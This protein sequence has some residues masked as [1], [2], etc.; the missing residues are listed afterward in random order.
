MGASGYGRLC[1]AATRYSDLW[2]TIVLSGNRI[3]T[4]QPLR[5]GAERFLIADINNPA[6]SASAQSNFAIM[7]DNSFSGGGY[8]KGARHCNHIPGGANVLY[9]D[10][11]VEWAKYPQPL[12]SK[13]YVMTAEAQGDET[14]ASP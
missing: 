14:W 7:W 13:A 5:E 9:M 12:G 2:A 6:S 3:V 8:V 1:I 11:H 10:G 4:A